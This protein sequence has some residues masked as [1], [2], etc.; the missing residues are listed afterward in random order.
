MHKNS[1]FSF[2]H[3]HCT[4]RFL[5]FCCSSL[6]TTCCLEFL[7]HTLE[8]QCHAVKGPTYIA[9]YLSPPSDWQMSFSQSAPVYRCD[10]TF[11]NESQLRILFKMMQKL[12]KLVQWSG[13]YINL[14]LQPPHSEKLANKVFIIQSLATNRCR[15]KT[16]FNYIC[17]HCLCTRSIIS[18][19]KRLGNLVLLK[20]PNL[21]NMG[22][23]I[24]NKVQWESGL[25][26]ILIDFKRQGH[27]GTSIYR[28]ACRLSSTTE[29]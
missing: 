7:T 27:K 8:C 11:Q 1:I 28:Q 9:D 26:S 3:P 2:G 10:C 4:M 24:K 20:T 29:M 17:K 25:V 12:S 19:A 22:V 23:P 15:F 16:P 6:L 14:K 18:D 5:F 13:Y 21:K